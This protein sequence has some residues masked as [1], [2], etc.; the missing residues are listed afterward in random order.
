MPEP[1]ITIPALEV[2][3]VEHCNLRCAGCAQVSPLMQ[4]SFAKAEQ[5]GNDLLQL[6]KHFQ[7]D[8]ITVLGGEP[9]LHPELSKILRT[10][11]ASGVSRRLHL[12]TN[13]LG[14]SRLPHEVWSLLDVVEVSIYPVSQTVF[15][16]ALQ[17]LLLIAWDAGVEL[18]LTPY[19]TFRKIISPR[20]NATEQ[21]VQKT[22]D[23]CYFKRF[24]NTISNGYFYACAP[25]V[26]IPTL[27]RQSDIGSQSVDG[28]DPQHRVRIDGSEAM[29]SGIVELLRVS[30]PLPECRHCLGSNGDEFNHHQLTGAQVKSNQLYSDT[31]SSPEIG[32]P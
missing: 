13:G 31:I 8:Q 23:A 16:T 3:A 19:K 12:T 20:R 30:A 6:S 11:R 17:Q 25:S 22:F 7:A 1:K 27:L 15:G 21:M 29:R 28:Q 5:I 9:T 32:E 2:R 26:N 14:L 10:I 4:K 24:T 18:R